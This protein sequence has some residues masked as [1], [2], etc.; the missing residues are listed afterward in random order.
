M[1]PPVDND[2]L[3]PGLKYEIARSN[4]TEL[5]FR[6]DDFGACA[7]R[8]SHNTRLWNFNAWGREA[9]TR[10]ARRPI[11]RNRSLDLR[12]PASGPRW[13]RAALGLSSRLR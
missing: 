13:P 10:A 11:G 5:I 7:A 4:R 2:A 9:S 6:A 3:V 1:R 12:V 8:R